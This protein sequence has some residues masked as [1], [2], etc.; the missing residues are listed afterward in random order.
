MPAVLGELSDEDPAGRRPGTRLRGTAADLG[1]RLPRRSRVPRG[2]K[3]RASRGRPGLV[4]HRGATN[5]V[6]VAVLLLTASAVVGAPAIIH[7]AP[8]QIDGLNLRMWMM[9]DF[10]AGQRRSRASPT[11]SSW[12]R[13]GSHEVLSG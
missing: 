2:H 13:S 10:P 1:L 6:A 12:S 4:E 8:R 9:L 7:A 5:P 3:V 11:R